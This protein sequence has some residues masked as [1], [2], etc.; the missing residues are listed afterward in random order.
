MLGAPGSGKIMLAKRV[1]T[2]MPTLT[3]SGSIEATRIYSALGRLEPGQ[4]LTALPH[5]RICGSPG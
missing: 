5:V 3:A 2:I 1:P 4:P